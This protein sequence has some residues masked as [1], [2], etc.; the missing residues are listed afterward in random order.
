MKIRYL[1][2]ANFPG[3]RA[4]DIQIVNTAAA[5]GELV[6]TRIIAPFPV[7]GD[8]QERFGR[9]LRIESLTGR[10]PLLRDVMFD[11]ALYRW[12]RRVDPDCV[13]Y[14]RIS[15]RRPLS[16]VLNS[17]V[18]VVGEL[19]DAALDPFWLR[20]IH[21]LDGIVCI[22]NGLREF[23][24][25][26]GYPPDRVI[27]APDGVALEPYEDLHRRSREELRR[28]LGLPPD[29]VIVGFTGHAY[30]DRGCDL[31]I[32]ALALLPK[33]CVVLLV[34]GTEPDLERVRGVARSLGL[35]NRVIITGAKLPTEVPG[36]QVASDVLVI[37][38]TS[39]LSTRDWCSPLKVFEYMAARRPIV[40]SDLRS[41]R[42]VLRHGENA[43]LF[44]PDDAAAL[45]A[46][47]REAIRRP[48]LGEAAGREAPKFTW[49]ARA[50][51]IVEFLQ[52]LDKRVPPP[53]PELDLSAAEL[54]RARQGR[55][56]LRLP[57]YFI[58][59]FGRSPAG[60]LRARREFSRLRRAEER[61]VPVTPP[62]LCR[63]GLLVTREVPG[64]PLREAIQSA[65]DRRELLR[66]AG[67]F[68]A[69]LAAR[70]LRHG[71]LH[72]GNIL[73]CGGRVLRLI[74]LQRASF[75]TGRAV[76]LRSAAELLTSIQSYITL[77]DMVRLLR[78]AGIEKR[79]WPRVRTIAREMAVRY[80]QSRSRRA[81]REHLVKFRDGWRF[82]DADEAAIQQGTPRRVNGDVRTVW[83]NGFLLRYAAVDTPEQLAFFADTIIERYPAPAEPL[84]PAGKPPEY[85]R[86]LG[87]FI[88]QVHER[89][90]WPGPFDPAL[91]LWVDGRF[92]LRGGPHTEHHAV[93]PRR[94]CDR[95]LQE[96]LAYLSEPAREPFR[97]GYFR[98]R[99]S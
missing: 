83:R 81:L 28:S 79:E 65:P 34:G 97:A 17:P 6:D 58:K 37:P 32:H 59:D 41:L 50:K 26:D 24:I 30:P 89:G 67:R 27:V 96:L 33:E 19:H 46:A 80:V 73:V 54:V 60:R 36:Y 10:V 90:V 40:S 47:I 72:G 48:E 78:A 53:V 77:T 2:R 68:L 99:A 4:H 91:I 64:V 94:L 63:G 85:Y 51:T 56:L 52:R 44:P 43:L 11:L 57:G 5:L 82:R 15:G 38:Y 9:K 87:W 70:G 45:A 61:G 69:R 95:Y 8:L 86:R 21:K 22:S 1:V 29:R 84:S 66:L 13:V 23:V 92:L 35:T 88:R 12:L 93:L 74:D 20:R 42:E 25:E 14:G 55:R 62:V 39:R 3:G 98:S 16:R 75:R 18:P 76:L 7:H 71:D 31:L 49:Q